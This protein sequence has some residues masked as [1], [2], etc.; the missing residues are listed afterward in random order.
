MQNLFKNLLPDGQLENFATWAFGDRY[1]EI[2]GSIN[3]MHAWNSLHGEEL[4]LRPDGTLLV[5][6]RKMVDLWKELE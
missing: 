3:F 4:L 6:A 2:E 5:D 1:W